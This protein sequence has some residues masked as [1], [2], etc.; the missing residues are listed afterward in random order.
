MEIG[1]PAG[2]VASGIA[3]FIVLR[4]AEREAPPPRRDRQAAARRWRAKSR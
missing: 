2:S 1:I 3:G 4:I